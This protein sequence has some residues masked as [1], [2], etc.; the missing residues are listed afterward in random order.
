M[1]TRSRRL[2]AGTLLSGLLA[3]GGA[4]TALA[5][6]ATVRV[7][8]ETTT[9][10][11]FEDVVTTDA[12]AITVGSGPNFSTNPPGTFAGG[13]FKCDGTN[14]GSS[15]PV[16]PTVHTALD[17][18]AK[19][20]GFD[21]Y[22]PYT[23]FD[24]F[25]VQ[26]IAGEGTTSATGPFWSELKNFAATGVGGCQG[27]GSTQYGPDAR[28]SDGDEVLFALGLTGPALK[29]TGPATAAKGAS[30]TVTV[31]DGSTNA[32][33]AGARVGT[34][35]TDAKGQATVRFAS[36]GLKRLKAEKAGAIRSNA[37]E[38]C[39]QEGDDGRCGQPRVI[40]IPA[41]NTSTPPNTNPT[42][43]V[44]PPF[45][46]PAV[47]LS[48]LRF[49][50][51]FSAARAPRVL[52]GTAIPGSEG[53][54]NVKLRLLRTVGNRCEYFSGKRDAFRRATCGR[55]Y[56]FSVGASESFSFLL[57][58]R[59]PRGRYALDALAYDRAGRTS[60]PQRGVTRFYFTV[61]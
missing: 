50:Q 8:V 32:P 41:P 23:S 40:T 49:K 56:F 31:V 19:A 2:V 28:V 21:W 53:L 15:G 54:V 43:P 48:G 13:T 22:G 6:P 47:R 57:P 10:T 38:L 3:A 51:V 33:V 39:V 61:R 36:P 55:G 24:D 14:G 44:A 25:F 34:S 7:R 59:L 46:P 26:T 58:S 45:R 9:Q 27:G 4:S 18:A 5:A 52:A 17:D 20:Y 12:H 35:T 1:N 42:P 30:A 37:L 16:G 29:L 60:T 11:L